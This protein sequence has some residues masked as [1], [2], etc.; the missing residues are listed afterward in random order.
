M[1]A[2]NLKIPYGGV[3][4]QNMQ[5]NL[6]VLDHQGEVVAVQFRNP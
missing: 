3:E 5:K 1:A 4:V 6:V 2:D